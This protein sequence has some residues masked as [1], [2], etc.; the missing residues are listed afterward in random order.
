MKILVNYDIQNKKFL[1]FLANL[2][3][4]Q[5]HYGLTTSKTYEIGN[6]LIAANAAQCDA[7]LLS[8]EETLA[9]C[10][11]SEEE[12]NPSLSTW[13]GSR[14]NFS[15]PTIV[16]SPLTHLKSLP[17]GEFVMRKDLAKLSQVKRKPLQLKYKLME[18]K[19]DREE[20]AAL[21][22]TS[23][24]ISIDIETDDLN[25]ITCI[26]FS[27]LLSMGKTITYLLPFWDF[28]VPHFLSDTDFIHAHSTMKTIVE[29]SVPKVFQNGLYDV[30]LLIGH[31]CWV[32]NWI[33]DTMALNYCKWSELP[34][35]LAFIASLYLY[36][37]YYWKEDKKT[38]DLQKF[39]LYNARDAW[40]TLRI[41]LHQCADQE[42]YQIRNY[43]EQ[44]RLVFPSLYCAFEGFKIDEQAKAEQRIEVEKERD[45]ALVNL[46]IMTCDATFN[47]GSSQQVATFIYDIIGAKPQK[48]YKGN[49]S[50][51]TDEKVLKKVALQHPLLERII[52]EIWNYREQ[53][54][55]I[56]TYFNA[57]PLNGR[58]FYSL[59][60]FGTDTG[61]M[62]SRKSNW[63]LKY[64]DEKNKIK[65]TGYG[66]QVQNIPPEAKKFLIADA[67][68]VVLEPDNNKS[69]ARCVSKLSKC[70]PMQQA[71]E[72][73]TKDFYSSL[74]TLF[75][76]IPYEQVTKALRNLV[77]KRIVH[78]TNYM[79]QE[80]TFIDNIGIPQIMEGTKL[81]GAH[82]SPNLEYD[83]TK[84]HF[85][86]IKQFAKFL[87]ES[88]HKP[89]P[90]V[91]EW[92]K[93]IKRKIMATKKLVSVLG[94]TRYFFGD[95]ENVPAVL[96][97][98]VAHEPQNLSVAILNRGWYKL[99]K[100]LVIPSN[101]EVR[102]KAQVHDSAPCQVLEEKKDYYAPLICKCLESTVMV[103][104]E[105]LKIPVDYKM[106]HSWY[107]AKG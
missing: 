19:K 89:F 51:S 50:R 57:V 81:L 40:N 82:I 23:K 31:Q 38:N 104:D 79:M 107:D 97:S 70:K 62:A 84:L 43:Q 46:Q 61:R 71:L 35:D 92:Y 5:G 99:Y 47:P 9:N 98:A 48:D 36:D 60:P 6:L 64:R 29:N 4:E 3:K 15:I 10:V 100:E 11:K 91:R 59:N 68:Y 101:G 63:R 77:L 27:A 25:R 88:Y 95:I 2:L 49:V 13:R 80:D 103:G 39:W 94:W 83:E 73:K 44:F 42:T 28:E 37:Y 106:G 86:N 45:K 41:F 24:L 67:G 21:L 72:D 78:G 22:S 34:K 8:N 30:Q 12:K 1:P 32:E 56:T 54:K 105:P 17:Y 26:S 96:R 93:V 58:L 55:L 18:T 76:G 74:G 69:E 14:L 85:Q 90:E 20:G 7:I 75:F 65:K 102:L 33:G 53:E 87:L 66:A 52:R 16:I